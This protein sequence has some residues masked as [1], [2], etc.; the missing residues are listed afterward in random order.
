[1]KE[2]AYTQAAPEVEPGGLVGEHKLC[3]ATV[4]CTITVC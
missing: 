2:L 3:A 1:M 4:L